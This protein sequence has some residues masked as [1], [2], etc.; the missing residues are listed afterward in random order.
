MRWFKRLLLLVFLGVAAL[1]AILVIRTAMF[2]SKQTQTPPIQPVAVN[3]QQAVERLAGALRL[4][5]ISTQDASKFDEKPF[6]ELHQYLE[7]TFPLV[8]ARLSREVINKYSL[9]YTWPGSDPSLKPIALLAHQDVVPVEADTEKDWTHPAFDG[10]VADGFLWGRGA[11]DDKGSLTGLLEAVEILLQEGFQPKRTVYLAFG[12]DEEVGGGH[13][14]PKIAETLRDKN[15]RLDFV[16]DEGSAIVQGVLPGMPNPVAI[17]GIAEKGYLSVELAV[18]SEGGHSSSPP[19]HTAIG[20]LAKAITRLEDHPFPAD[21]TYA[22]QF[23][24]YVGPEMPFLQRMVFANLWLTSPLVKMILSGNPVVNASIRTT[25][26]ATIFNAGFKE[27]VLPGKATAIINF[28]IQPGEI[29]DGVIERVRK[30][31]GDDR[32]SVTPL[33]KPNNP[34]PVSSVQSRGYQILQTTIQQTLAEPGTVVAPFLVLGATDSRHYASIAD[35]VLRF[36]P[37]KYVPE[38]LKRMHGVNER[39]GVEA[40]ARSVQF[41]AQLIRNA[42]QP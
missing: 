7:R 36:E 20:I 16:L 32:V 4:R 27:N 21:M 11:T 1:V 31:I 34:S 29:A 5:T 14:A 41:Y 38:D 37:L 2:T 28:R 25:G 40:Y 3:A 8:H 33:G 9:L 23:F 26:A 12:H 18:E 22:A 13:G 39:V 24:D 42:D 35:A 15:V 6:F 17:V 30:T 19:K 10:I